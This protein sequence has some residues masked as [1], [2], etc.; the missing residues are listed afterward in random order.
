M[1]G[2][3]DV[4]TTT[5]K[6]WAGLWVRDTCKILSYKERLET[7]WKNKRDTLDWLRLVFKD[8]FVYYLHFVL[9][10]SKMCNMKKLWTI[11]GNWYHCHCEK[12]HLCL[13]MYQNCWLCIGTEKYLFQWNYN[14][15][16]PWKQG[17]ILYMFPRWPIVSKN[18]C[19]EILEI[20]KKVVHIL[21]NDHKNIFNT[22]ILDKNF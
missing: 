3:V 2:Q 16:Q 1:D 17:S 13:N 10:A 5:S 4:K 6:K 11:K 14:I 19:C 12:S 18:N 20:T 9:K 7:W 15:W 22:T 21:Q 8:D